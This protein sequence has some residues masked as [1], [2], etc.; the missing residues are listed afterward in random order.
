MEITEQQKIQ[1]NKLIYAGGYDSNE[2]LPYIMLAALGIDLGDDNNEYR[3]KS[4]AEINALIDKRYMN[5]VYNLYA[6]QART[7]RSGEHR[8]FLKKLPT[9]VSLDEINQWA[10]DNEYSTIYLGPYKF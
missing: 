3:N 7:N 6:Y 10:I 4:E 5:F 8:N 1:L 2:E 9:P